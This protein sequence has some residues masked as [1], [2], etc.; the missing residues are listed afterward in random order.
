M[1]PGC[2]WQHRSVAG[3]GC[4]IWAVSLPSS[5]ALLSALQ[6]V[7]FHTSLNHP[8]IVAV[9]EVVTEGKERGG[10]LQ[11][12]S[13]GFGILQI[14]SSRPDSSTSPSQDKR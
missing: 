9:V 1:A 11:A 12:L 8:N 13:C 2:S 3:R 5:C 7:Y 10:A 4:G 14:F 6:P